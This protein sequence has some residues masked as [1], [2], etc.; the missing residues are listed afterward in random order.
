VKK[1]LDHRVHEV[2][3]STKKSP[4][5]YKPTGE[6]CAGT[7]AVTPLPPKNPRPRGLYG[8]MPIPSSLKW[9]GGLKD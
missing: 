2:K 5:N 7:V 4:F 9:R 6:R 1:R 8:T 3:Y